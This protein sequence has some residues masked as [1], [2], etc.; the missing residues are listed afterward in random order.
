ML[1][2]SIDLQRGRIVQLVQGEKLAVETA[3][4]TG[5]IDR[6][7]GFPRI[8]LVDLDAAKR[9]G[10]NDDLV[11]TICGLL[12]CRVGGGIRTIRQARRVL[13]A[14]ATDVILGSAFFAG[15]AVDVAFA[16]RIATAIGPERLIAAIDSRGGHIVICGWRTT[17]AI[18]PAEA[19]RSLEPYVGEFLYTQVDREGLMRGTDIPSIAA[20]RDATTRRVTAAGGV[21]TLDEIE[22]LDALGVDAVVGMAFYTGRIE[23]N[24]A[25]LKAE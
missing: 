6:F 18:T 13:E 9:E 11:S 10:S 5:W 23:V 21:T 4:V 16:E 19:A 12:P 24:R 14:G 8:Q 7:R 22:Q 1:I 20:I 2:P 25:M 17:L 15:D 3:D